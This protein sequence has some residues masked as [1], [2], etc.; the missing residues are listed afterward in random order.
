M[1]AFFWRVSYLSHRTFPCYNLRYKVGTSANPSGSD[2]F[3]C[4]I[5]DPSSFDE[6]SFCGE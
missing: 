1:R 6:G 5:K 3:V 4:K 2:Q